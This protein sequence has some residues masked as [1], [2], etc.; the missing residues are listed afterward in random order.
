MDGRL[1]WRVAQCSPAGLRMYEESCCTIRSPDPSDVA[2]HKEPELPLL[3]YKAKRV[4]Q[5]SP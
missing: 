5:Q 4:N 1:E 2:S 3:P